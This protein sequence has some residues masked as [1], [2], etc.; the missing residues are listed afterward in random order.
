MSTTQMPA[1]R[2][3]TVIAAVD[4][5]HNLLA[6]PRTA[7]GSIGYFDISAPPATVTGKRP[8]QNCINGLNFTVGMT[9]GLERGGVRGCRQGHQDHHQ[10]YHSGQKTSFHGGASLSLSLVFASVFLQY[11]KTK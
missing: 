8:Q 11:H 6:A 2:I 5:G 10:C 7:H 9:V 1:I 3:T 4:V